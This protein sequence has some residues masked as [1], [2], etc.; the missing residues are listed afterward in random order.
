MK[1]KISLAVAA[2]LAVFLSAAAFAEEVKLST[3]YPSPYGSYKN[4]DSSSDTHLATTSG[5]VGIGTAGPKFL[6]DVGGTPA[7]T[8]VSTVG[9]RATNVEP[10]LALFGST[11]N[12]ALYLGYEPTGDYSWIFAYD[13]AGNTSKNIVLNQFGGNVGIGTTTPASGMKLD[14]NGNVNVGGTIKIV[15]GTPGIGK[16]LTSDENGNATWQVPTWG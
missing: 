15:G 7:N 10:A 11:A 4:L 12:K 13:R 5:K 8:N 6:L 2:S 3:Y 1:T 9:I 16:V 14:V